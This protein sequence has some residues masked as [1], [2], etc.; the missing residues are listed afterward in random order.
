MAGFDVNGTVIIKYP[1]AL[2][3]I[4]MNTRYLETTVHIDNFLLT[5]IKLSNEMKFTTGE[6]S[7]DIVTLAIL[8]KD[9]RLKSQT[10]VSF[11]LFQ[12]K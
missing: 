1:S 12:P 9:D 8:H 4:I 7:T 10:K 2:P 3:V 11:N 6:S 5:T